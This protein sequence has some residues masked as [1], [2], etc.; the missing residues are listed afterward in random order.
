MA[1]DPTRDLLAMQEQLDSLFG[2]ASSGWVP[3]ADLHEADDRFVL[4]LEVPGLTRADID[5]S[6]RDQTLTVKGERPGGECPQRYQRL[7]R[8]HG[9]FARAFSFGHDVDPDG[10]SAEMADGG[11]TVTIPKTARTT[12]RRIDVQ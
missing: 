6:F 5:L 9:A 3:A 8:G 7:E 1:W 2:R 4:T 10:I 11:L 12:T